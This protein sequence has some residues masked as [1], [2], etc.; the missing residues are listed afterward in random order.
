MV[1]T[2]AAARG[3]V[4]APVWEPEAIASDW[5][6][7]EVST[8]I[9]IMAMQ[10]DGDMILEAMTDKLTPVHGGIFCCHSGSAAD[11]Q[12]EADAVTY[13]L[14]L[15]KDLMAGIIIEGWDSQEGGQAFTT[16]DSGSSYIYGYVEAT[17]QEG[18]T[19]KECL[20]STDSSSSSMICLAAIAQSGVEW[21]VL[22]DEIVQ[23]TI[24][25]LS[26]L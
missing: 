9:P 1:A 6:N 4:P 26:P 2:L 23:F 7:Q 11:T 10:F 18:M 22:G 5:E 20:Q 8:G 21:Q 24:A 14:G 25:T 17:Y 16:G 19:K 13:Q 15:H 3:G 12:A